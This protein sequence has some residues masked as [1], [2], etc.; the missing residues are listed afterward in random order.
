MSP[1]SKVEV[2]HL[3]LVSVP[4]FWKHATSSVFWIWE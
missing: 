4:I 2:G 1:A 3:Y